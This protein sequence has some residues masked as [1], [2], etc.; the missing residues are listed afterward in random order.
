[1]SIILR[2]HVPFLAASRAEAAAGAATERSL[3]VVRDDLAGSVLLVSTCC[4]D[5][6]IVEAL[7]RAGP[8]AAPCHEEYVAVNPDRGVT[9]AASSQHDH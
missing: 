2:F 7:L 6:A 1:M 8:I 4:V 9:D 5:M 3:G